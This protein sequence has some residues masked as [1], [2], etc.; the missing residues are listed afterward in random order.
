MN[1]VT[2]SL[3][4]LGLKKLKRMRFYVFVLRFLSV[5]CLCIALATPFTTIT[6]DSDGDP[7]A[8]VLV[9]KSA[10]MELY[11]TSFIDFL[12]EEL[13]K[14]LPTTVK[15]FGTEELS[16]VGDAA[17]GHSEHVL[18]ISDGNANTGVDILDVAHA[19]KDNNVSLNMVDLDPVKN[20]VAVV[21]N[22]P[23]SVPLGF[24]ARI[25]VEVSS[26]QEKTVPLTILVDGAEF[27]NELTTGAVSIEPTLSTGYHRIE[28]RVQSNDENLENNV[29]YAVIQVLEK[30]KIFVLSGKNGPLEQ[31]L[32]NLFDTTRAARLPADLSPYLA[33]V[34][35]DQNVNNVNA[36]TD[37]L[38][39]EDGDRYGNG[40]VVFGGF[41]SYDR[42]Q[43]KGKQIES[44]LP[45][46]VGKPKRKTGENTIVFVIQVSGSTSAEKVVVDPATGKRTTITEKEPTIDIIK[47]QAVNAMNNLNLKNN[48]GVIAF[49]VG[50][51]GKSFG[52]GQ[53]AIEA[54][55]VKIADIQ[56][57]YK[58]RKEIVDKVSRV[59][60]GGT[61]A[62]DI[63]LRAAVDMLRSK[64][65]D[66]TIIFLTNGRFSAGLTGGENVPIKVNT[67]EIVKNAYLRYGIKTHTLGVGSRDDDIFAQKV[68]ET[69]L[70]EVAKSGDSTYDRAT[71]M[72][73]LL[74]KYGDPHE[75]GF[76]ENFALVPLSLT[77]FIT[78]DTD[79]NAILNGYNE[80]VPKDGSK[81]LVTT[82]TGLPA[83][84][85]WNY[86]NGRVAA[87]TVFTQ[88]GLG[89][90]MQGSNSDLV[91]NAVLWAS[92][93]PRRNLDVNV[94]VGQAIIDKQTEVTFTSDDPVSGDCQDTKLTFDRSAGNSYIFHFTPTS[95]G[96]FTVCNIPYA[97]N[98][99]SEH[100]RVGEH[101][102][103]ETA[104]GITGGS[105][106][107]FD[108]VDAIVERIKTVSKRVIV[109][110]TEVRG[111][112]IALA[113]LLFLLE[114]FIRRLT[115]RG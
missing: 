56:P 10:S 61:T 76:G 18:L 106:F 88:N 104:V 43:Y 22:A 4:D 97:V 28:A 37:F 62:P 12:T 59:I 31:A 82:D 53:E 80:V 49:G 55:V 23:T 103:L 60:G 73:S 74:V 8:L 26:S 102:D 36:L 16:P 92:G 27:Y 89:P 81:L 85:T 84:T 11:D 101:Q 109:E 15:V 93:D 98:D 45:V 20:D 29:H 14:E 30:P 48:V 67:I 113:A 44:L 50:T 86:F 79:I 114:I 63:A 87:F 38:R 100:W 94:Q 24:P 21:V 13:N 51:T 17:L 83:V 25:T 90:L 72:M 66:K 52:S 96:F 112:F 75:K 57:L 70:K 39:D 35:N 32:A 99:A 71:N 95:T 64:S 2:Y 41:N 105:K 58:N 5:A 47:A 107:T 40:L 3:D 1:F 6:E 108:Q 34:V 42:G 9:D 91:R 7:R 46:K 77:H 33:V 69:F 78:R 54:S 19:A 65:G 68:D 111:P 110:K 115:K